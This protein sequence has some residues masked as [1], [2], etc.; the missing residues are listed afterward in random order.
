MKS[1]I[2]ASAPGSLMLLGEHAVLHG[3]RAVATTLSPRI[4]VILR[5]RADRTLNIFSRLGEYSSEVSELRPRPPF[6]FLLTAVSTHSDAFETGVDIHV[7]S[8]FS[9]RV[10]LGSSAAVTVATHAAVLAWLGCETGV[11]RLFDLALNTI[12]TV[13]GLGS[14][15]DA[16]AS[17]WGGT[18]AYRQ[19][20]RDIRRLST[21]CPL[22]VVYS[23][24]KCPT[25]EVVARV[26]EL[27]RQNRELY[28]TLFAAIGRIVDTSIEPL[29]REDWPALGRLF[30]IH[31]GL[32]D[33][34]GVNNATL[35]AIA[36]AL[37]AQDGIFGSKISGAGLGDCV[38]GLGAARSGITAY[39]VLD[40]ETTNTG[41]TVD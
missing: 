1:S 29:E 28:D 24:G 5:T 39:E 22:T 38:I 25:P 3:H 23:G 11:E 33:A 37:R 16:A 30:N 21:L 26:Q 15:A 13:Q 14:G 32:L 2:S 20:P 18:V 6:E 4:K 27:R 10:G 41:V 9:E 34:L 8:D 17:I 31:Q 19:A 36:Y 12:H 35:A 7:A 40:I